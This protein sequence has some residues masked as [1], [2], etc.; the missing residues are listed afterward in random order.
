M[1]GIATITSAERTSN[2]IVRRRDSQPA[3]DGSGVLA[4][5]LEAVSEMMRGVG[6][7]DITGQQQENF[8]VF[9]NEDG[10]TRDNKYAEPELPAR[11]A[12]LVAYAVHEDPGGGEGAQ[13]HVSPKRAVSLLA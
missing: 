10:A 12:A 6:F 11:L 7:I 5:A 13:A 9:L 3:S 4:R 1:N 2:L 8:T